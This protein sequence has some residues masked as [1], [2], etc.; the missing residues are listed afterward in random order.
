MVVQVQL[1]KI[2]SSGVKLVH[3]KIVMLVWPEYKRK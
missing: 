2:I 3:S 1:R